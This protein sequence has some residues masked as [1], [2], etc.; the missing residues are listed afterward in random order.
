M[1]FQTNKTN[2][3]SLI[4]RMTQIAFVVGLFLGIIL[5]WMFSGVV[6]AVVQFGFVAIALIIFLVALFFWWNIRR[7]PKN[8]GGGP[9][10]YTWTSSGLPQMQED[11]FRESGVPRDNR[12]DQD[13]IDLEE[14]RRERD[15]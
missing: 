10:V 4:P 9:Q 2:I 8:V 7:G 5:G 1:Q 12:R 3:R 13:V 11:L 14:L 6:G 15:Q